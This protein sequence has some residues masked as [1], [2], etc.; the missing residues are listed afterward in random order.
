MDR[1]EHGDDDRDVLARDRLLMVEPIPK[2]YELAYC[3]IIA[4][5]IRL[6]LIRAHAALRA[7]GADYA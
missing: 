1:D 2:L 7:L 4:V 6:M 5:A 3:Y